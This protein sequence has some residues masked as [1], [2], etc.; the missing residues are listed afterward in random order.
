MSEKSEKCLI[1][2]GETSARPARIAKFLVARCD[3]KT[4]K[5]QIRYCAHCDF[6]FFE[7]RLS[8]EEATRLYTDYRGADYNALRVRVE[9]VYEPLICPFAD[10]LS[11]Y[12]NSRLKEYSNILSLFPEI[13]PRTVL[14]FGG[15]GTLPKRLFPRAEVSHDDLS[16][17]VS[18][19]TKKY[20]FVFASQVFE[21][22][23]HPRA[24]LAD[25]VSRLHKESVVFIDVPIEYDSSLAEGLLFQERH[26]GALF[27]MHEHINH[28]SPRSLGY[29]FETAS[30]ATFFE[31]LPVL[32]FKDCVALGAR[33]DSHIAK[34]LRPRAVE[35]QN[36]WTLDASRRV[37]QTALD[38]VARL[39]QMADAAAA[40][41]ANLRQFAEQKLRELEARAAAQESKLDQ[42]SAA[43][44]ALE[45]RAAAQESK[46][47]QI[48]AAASATYSKL[49]KIGALEA[50]L[51]EKDARLKAQ[52][53]VIRAMGK[54]IE[55]R[56]GA[57]NRILAS[58]SWRMTAP[59]RSAA[60]I[61]RAVSRAIRTYFGLRRP[62]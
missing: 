33:R 57:L 61:Q 34:T 40:H 21:H 36:I 29:L 5:T 52:E 15:D 10:P 37:G 56:S 9:S 50:R 20:D 62:Q 2:S 60:T 41:S 46:L 47:D 25:L 27:I 35:R 54:E 12:Y 6:A 23:S 38:A 16:A 18:R 43:V 1:C 24:M 19:E 58:S 3:F 14:D 17:G 51:A 44:S 8:E 45:V 31:A 48:G 59:I 26:G 39:V 4:D 49:D 55:D 28:F 53:E 42:I 7:R 30:L 11:D 32:G 22:L 13:N